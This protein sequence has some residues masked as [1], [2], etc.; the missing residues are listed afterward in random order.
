MKTILTVC[1]MTAPLLAIGDEPTP[2]SFGKTKDGVAVDMYTLKSKGGL[3]AK[4]MTR[5]ATLVELHVPDKDGNIDDVILGWDDVAG[6]ES[7]G[8]QYFGCTTGRVCNR[9]KEG[10]FSLDGKDYTLAVNNEPN[11]LHGG[12]ERSLDK[13]VWK[14]K[15][16]ANDRGTGVRFTYTSPMVKKATR[17]N[18]RSRFRTLSQLKKTA[19]SSTTRRPPIRRRPSI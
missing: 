17:E 11:H 18:L 19:S 15:G 13:V 14:A 1:L 10:K 8:N 12:V 4:I 3:V 2:E 9:I 7:D 6:Y 5:G 16:Y